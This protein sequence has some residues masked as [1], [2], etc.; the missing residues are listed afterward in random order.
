MFIN[1]DICD[2]YFPEYDLV[3]RWIGNL[4]GHP[5]YYISEEGRV[6]RYRKST[7]NSYL[8]ALCVGQS[9]YYTTNIRELETGRNRMFYNHILVYKAFVGDYDPSTHNLW[10]IDGDP[11]NPRL[12]NLELITRSEKGKR[13]DYMKR[14][15]DWSAIVDEFGALV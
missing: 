11:L 9:G 1:Q 8:R 14:D 15:I 13:V 2:R 5:D 7:G 3:G 12:D 10:F 6:I 4:V